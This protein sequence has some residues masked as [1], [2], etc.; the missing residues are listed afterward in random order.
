MLCELGIN[1]SSGHAGKGPGLA[2]PAAAGAAAASVGALGGGGA[3]GLG[4]IS[5]FQEIPAHGSAS[6]T[7]WQKAAVGMRASYL[8]LQQAPAAA[9]AAAIEGAGDGLPKSEA[10]AAGGTGAE[11]VVGHM[12]GLSALR[13]PSMFDGIGAGVAGDFQ[14]PALSMCGDSMGDLAL[15]GGLNQSDCM[16]EDV[17]QNYGFMDLMTLDSWS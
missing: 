2:E 4:G 10:A 12:T 8:N 13:G 3:G 16:M 9:G 7:Q 11:V 6:T 5:M 14:L 1:S 17:P 15:Q